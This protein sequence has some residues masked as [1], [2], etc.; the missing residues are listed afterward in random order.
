MAKND[1]FGKSR[2]HPFIPD[3]F[4]NGRS[5]KGSD[6]PSGHVGHD[7]RLDISVPSDR[8][9]IFSISFR[10]QHGRQRPIAR[11]VFQNHVVVEFSSL[12]PSRAV[13]E[14]VAEGE[15]ED[16]DGRGDDFGR[17]ALEINGLVAALGG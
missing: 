10:E 7:F 5:E 3:G 16:H 12:S 11:L 14:N 2:I 4:I 6:L 1:I 17:D 13:D 8:L 15:A 9:E